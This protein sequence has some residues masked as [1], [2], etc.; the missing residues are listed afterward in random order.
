[1]NFTCPYCNQHT[2]ITSPNKDADWN[3]IDIAA[4]QLSYKHRLG[5]RYLAISCPNKK[6]KRLTFSLKLTGATNVTYNSSETTKIVQKWDLLPETKAKPQPSYITKVVVQDYIE[7]CRISQLSPKASAALARR[8]LQGMIRDF[9]SVK[10]DTLFAEIDALKG[11]IPNDEWEAIDA[12]RSI[13]NIGAHMEK[14]VNLIIDI[15]ENEADKLIAFI[16]YLFRQWYIKR[17][18][19]QENLAAVKAMAGIKQEQRKQKPTPKQSTK[20]SKETTK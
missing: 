2:T 12:L 3:R 14:D 9:H 8:C 6:C 11:V 4:E 19:D 18:D 7:A 1:M 15:D 13:G 10:K 20:T 16:E 5:I 17:H